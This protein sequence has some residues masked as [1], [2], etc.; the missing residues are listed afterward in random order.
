MHVLGLRI[1]SLL[2]WYNKIRTT[3]RSEIVEPGR[4]GEESAAVACKQHNIT[5]AAVVKVCTCEFDR[6]LDGIVTWQSYINNEFSLSL[7]HVS[8]C[9]SEGQ[10]L[11]CSLQGESKST[12]PQK[13]LN[14]ILAYAT[15]FWAKFC[16]V[17]MQFISRY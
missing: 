16:P 10:V 12:P 11:H 17:K 13:A 9:N 1:P 2:S 3:A 8:V 4:N 15:P 7:H 6:S 5:A 14:N